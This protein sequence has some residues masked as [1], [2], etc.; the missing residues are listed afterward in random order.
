MQYEI[1]ITVY[2]KFMTVHYSSECKH[3]NVEYNC[4]GN[5]RFL[6]VSHLFPVCS[7][8]EVL[9]HFREQFLA[10]VDAKAIIFE[11]YQAKIV[12]YSEMVTILRC[13]NEVEMNHILH[14]ILKQRCDEK[15]LKKV[16]DV[17][18]K[19]SRMGLL[20]SE[21]RNMLDRK[22]GLHLCPVNA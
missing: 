15:N 14:D 8:T 4:S 19:I 16:C 22:L 11:L 2:L 20:A 10:E 3:Q 6:C 12:S 17:M 7:N 18:G 9:D 21:M 1:I 13:D 5:C